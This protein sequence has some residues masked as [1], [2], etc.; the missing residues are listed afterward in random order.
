[1]RLVDRCQ[2]LRHQFRHTLDSPQVELEWL[3]DYEK[4]YEAR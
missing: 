2:S 1:M 3:E 4:G